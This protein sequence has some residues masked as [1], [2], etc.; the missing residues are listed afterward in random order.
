MS[1]G[2][3]M[4]KRK[5]EWSQ[6]NL[7][8]CPFALFSPP[9]WLFLLPSLLTETHTHAYTHI[10]THT[11]THTHTHSMLT[12]PVSKSRGFMV[13]CGEFNWFSTV[14]NESW[15][16]PVMKK[17]IQWKKYWVNQRH[18]GRAEN[19]I[20]GKTPW[21]NTPDLNRGGNLRWRHHLSLHQELHQTTAVES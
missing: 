11:H 14:N 1:A 13:F 9:L 4:S 19:Q 17:D 7:L 20:Q 16:L 2:Y 21:S 3:V 5:T 12:L 8:W 15:L 10:H 6:Q 18:L